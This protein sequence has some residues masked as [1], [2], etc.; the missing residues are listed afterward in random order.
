MIVFVSIC[1][2]PNKI[3]CFETT[4]LM[5]FNT[6]KL[7]VSKEYKNLKPEVHKVAKTL[8]FRVLRN[9]RKEEFSNKSDLK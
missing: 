3:H 4:I 5:K 9:E 2:N 7:K 6:Q 1:E 8:D